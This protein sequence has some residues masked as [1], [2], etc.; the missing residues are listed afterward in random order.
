VIAA[1]RTLSSKPIR[2]LVNTTSDPD[3]LGGNEAL[4]KAGTTRTGGV[5]VGQIGALGTANII[6]HENMLNRISA[7]TGGKAA[8]PFAAQPTETFFGAKKDMLFNG[9]GVQFLHQ[10]AA[11]T[12]G[13]IMVYF[14]RSDVLATGDLISTTGYPVIDAARGGTIGGTI[15]ALNRIIDIAIPSNTQEG[16]TMIIPGHGRVAD[17]MDV[18][19]YR[20]MVTIVRD[21][22]K[23]MIDR[24]MTLAQVQAAK[25][26]FDFDARY[27]G[28]PA[29][30]PA[31]VCYGVFIG[32][33][34]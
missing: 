32:L 9:E 8:V 29:W 2:H 5:V 33:C 31:F 25:P 7:P 13:D 14:R 4:A 19:E 27:G 24:K 23:D 28:D 11:H 16:G 15:D 20:D 18:V 26:T 6:A 21:R 3:H 17:E 30:T 1:I 10:P 34:Y 12:D 22:V